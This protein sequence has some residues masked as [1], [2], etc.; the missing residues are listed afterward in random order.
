MGCGELI[1]RTQHI[2]IHTYMDNNRFTLIISALLITF[3]IL[4]LVATVVLLMSYMGTAKGLEYYHVVN[5]VIDVKKM[6]Q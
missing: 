5:T 1:C 2:L 4:V 3:F 6:L